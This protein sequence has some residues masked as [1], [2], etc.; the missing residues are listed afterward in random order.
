MIKLATIKRYFLPFLLGVIIIFFDKIVTD[1]LSGLLEYLI[2]FILFLVALVTLEYGLSGRSRKPQ[3]YIPK[4]FKRDRIKQNSE[5]ILL[6]LGVASFD[7]IVGD[8]IGWVSYVITSTLFLLA[9]IVFE[10]KLKADLGD[11]NEILKEKK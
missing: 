11:A 4:I 5:S 7:S 1:R 9:L 6:G 10:A 2:K 3:N 8:E